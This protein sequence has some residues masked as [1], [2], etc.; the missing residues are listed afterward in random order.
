LANSLSPRSSM[1]R[2][3]PQS[4]NRLLMMARTDES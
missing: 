2:N 4:L 3:V 1:Q